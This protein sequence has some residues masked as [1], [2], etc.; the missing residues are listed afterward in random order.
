MKYKPDESTLIDYLYGELDPEEMGRVQA[1]L[2]ENP[3]VKEELVS[4]SETRDMLQVLP[5]EPVSP[6]LLILDEGNKPRI[7]KFLRPNTWFQQNW[8]GGVAATV[9]ILVMSFL[10]SRFDLSKTD[11]GWT[12]QSR[13]SNTQKALAQ[14]EAERTA[15]QA[16]M[17]S[18]RNW[19]DQAM[20]RN[21]DSMLR[22]LQQSM[23]SQMEVVQR[24]S[25]QIAEARRLNEAQI[26]KLSKDIRAENYKTMIN[27]V[28]FAN[29]Q[30]K[31]YTQQ[32]LEEFALVLEEQRIQDLSRIEAVFARMIDQADLEQQQTELMWAQLMKQLEE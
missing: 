28:S 3:E 21:N 30:Q 29:Q 5:D 14:L 27:M 4:M 8:L 15:H 19:V 16:E 31:V 10:L 11:Q 13:S 17:D 18:L 26:A 7:G 23:D 22:A 20:Q 12:L 32:I 6:P 2:D 1:Y 25:Q 24:Q 9:S